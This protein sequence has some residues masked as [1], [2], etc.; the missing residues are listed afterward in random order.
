MA[1]GMVGE[2]VEAGVLAEEGILIGR[3]YTTLNVPSAATIVRCR[4]SQPVRG[5]SI[6]AIG[7]GACGGEMIRDGVP[8]AISADPGLMTAARVHIAG[9]TGEHL[10]AKIM[11]KLWSCSIICRLKWIK[12]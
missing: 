8:A 7:L 3:L 2:V 12:F 10:R 6:A 4:L 11:G 1:V 9:I 5:L